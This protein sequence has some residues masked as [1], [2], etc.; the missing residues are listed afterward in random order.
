MEKKALNTIRTHRLLIGGEG[1]IVGLSGG[2]DST[3]LLLVLSGLRE[4]LGLK[5][6][7]VHINHMLRGDEALRDEQFS[8]ALCERYQIPIQVYRVDVA[9]M[10]AERGISFEMA[11]REARYEH[12]ERERASLEYQKI[13]VAHHRDDQGETVLLRLIRGSGLEGLAGIRPS[14]EGCVI[15]P[16]LECSRLEIEAYCAKYG[17]EPM[18][19]HTNAD[20]AY[21]RN[22][23]RNQI[24]PQIDRQF[25]ISICQQLSKTAELL[26]ED[27]DFIQGEVLKLWN[28]LVEQ[29][30]EGFR[31]QKT[32]IEQ[33]HPAIKS[34]LIRQ[35]YA[36]IS[37]NLLDL[38]LAHVQQI[39]EMTGGKGAKRFVFKSVEFTAEHEW[40]SVAGEKTPVTVQLAEEKPE[41]LMDVVTDSEE[42][43]NRPKDAFIYVDQEK[44]K[45][46]LT[47]RH[48]KSGDIFMP[49]GMKGHKK[50]KDFLIDEKISREMRDRLWLLCDD[51]K[52]VWVCGYR[53][54]EETRVTKNTRQILR[55]SLSDV[56]THD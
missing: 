6:K 21:S 8:V 4:T 54:S 31:I 5:L 29:T 2:A 24:I 14:R 10:A 39:L 20:S 15:R 55:L 1:V 50:L 43:G 48:R 51:E 41:I 52:I 12:F 53:Q 45:G 18:V 40:L 16:L 27:G 37:G 23:I 19:D 33:V 46:Q 38:Q 13:A 35:L 34:R 9:K 28:Q 44:L 25:G 22:F 36:S 11:G 3:A 26:A 47:L 17:I 30:P 56:V 7:A 49:F 42:M 32:A